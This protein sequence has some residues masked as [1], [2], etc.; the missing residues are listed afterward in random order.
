MK[1]LCLVLSGLIAATVVH[2]DESAEEVSR[3]ER[4]VRHLTVALAEARSEA[5]LL[6]A[7][8]DERGLSAVDG[9]AE[10]GVVAAQVMHGGVRVLDANRELSMVVID[11][12]SRKGVR[13]GM[14]M[15]VMRGDRPVARVTV[16]DVRREVAGAVVGDARS[17]AYPEPGDRL[18][19]VTGTEE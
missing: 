1:L 13:L 12:G 2:G 17:R 11:A 8:L 18:V 7:R 9:V 3:L 10:P 5:D 6:R 16:I 19:L 15:M 4:Q 14:A